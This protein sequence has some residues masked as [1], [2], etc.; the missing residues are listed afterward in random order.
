MELRCFEVLCSTVL[1]WMVF[2]VTVCSASVSEGVSAFSY[3]MAEL[4]ALNSGVRCVALDWDS[5]PQE[6]KLIPRKRTRRGGVRQRNRRRKYKPVLP[7]VIMG[8]VRSISNKID[9]LNACVMHQR[10]FQQCSL[11]CFS[12]TWLNSDKDPDTKVE[13]DGFYCVRMDRDF[14]TTGKMKGGG[15]CLYINPQWCH[16][17]HMTV[18]ERV[19]LPDAELLVVS[20]RP[21]YVPRE[22]SHVLVTVVYIHP[23]ANREAAIDAVAKSVSNQQAS[24]PDGLFIVTGDFNHCSLKA[25]LPTFRQYVSVSTRGDNTLDHFYCNAKDAYRVETL[26]PLGRSDHCLTYFLPKYTPV[27]KRQPVKIRTVQLW[28]PEAKEALRG[29][30]ECTDWGVFSDACDGDIDVFVESVTGYINF[31]VDSV[32]PVKV[33]RCYANNKPWI[34]KDI[35]EVLN[36]KKAA[37]DKGCKEELKQVQKELKVVIREGKD[38]YKR[39]LESKLEGNGMK[40]VWDGMKLITGYSKSNKS[41]VGDFSVSYA[42][43]LNDFYARF[44]VHDF[45]TERENVFYS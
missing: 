10:V 31:C 29:C 30:M 16:P 43:E 4:R 3:N 34:T 15:V 23:K 8:N 40:E 18:K 27:V 35:K 44:D 5:L 13:V 45:K 1:L 6:M 41:D 17:N 25:T 22:F 14:L 26:P 28:T 33:V 36:K 19:C 11:M 37:F 12:E 21:Y 20:L 9:E 38:R 2:Y 39:K 24:S 32:I 7:T 42:D